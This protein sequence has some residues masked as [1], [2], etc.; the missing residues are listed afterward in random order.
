MRDCDWRTPAVAWS[1]CGLRLIE[2][3]LGV[4]MIE[5][6]DHLALLD[7]IADIHRRGDDASGDQRRDVAGFVGDE[8][9]GL[10]EAGR[11]SAGDG[12]GGR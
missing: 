8:G 6:A 9:A 4:A 1:S 2:A 3:E 12:L 5:F 10:L 7:E 11:N